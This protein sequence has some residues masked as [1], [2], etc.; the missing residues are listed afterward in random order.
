MLI[1]IVTDLFNSIFADLILETTQSSSN[2]KK[3][4]GRRLT[5]LRE[6]ESSQHVHKIETGELE[7][8]RRA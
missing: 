8:K 6:N 1:L 5:F 3:K 4:L 7:C 2:K